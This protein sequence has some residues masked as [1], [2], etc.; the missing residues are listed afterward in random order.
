MNLGVQ[1]YRA[2]FPDPKHWDEDL[3][4]M[5]DSGLNT[6]QLWV[7]WGWVEAT[8]D[9]FVYDD[10][11]RLVEL[12]GRTSK[13]LLSLPAG[14]RL[15]ETNLLEWTDE[16]VVEPENGKAALTFKPFEIRTFKVVR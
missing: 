10:Y 14:T 7:S 15:V 8:P 6:V 12:A 1:Y 16:T 4:K 9:K 2:P 13:A 3:R 11:D 5:R